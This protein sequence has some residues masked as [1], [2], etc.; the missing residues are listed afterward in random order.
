MT[1]CLEN[2]TNAIHLNV[3]PKITF[4]VASNVLDYNLLMKDHRYQ[5]F[6]VVVDV[7]FRF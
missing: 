4:I 3:H 5:E 6:P 1:K 7:F 2:M